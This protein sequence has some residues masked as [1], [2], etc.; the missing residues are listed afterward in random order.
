MNNG[1]FPAPVASGQFLISSASGSSIPQWSTYIP[2]G[3][4]QYDFDTNLGA[5][6]YIVNNTDIN[7][8][9]MV[10]G[11]TPVTIVLPISGTTFGQQST[12][13]AQTSQPITFSGVSGTNVVSVGA[14]PAMPQLRQIYS[15]ATATWLGGNGSTVNEWIVIGDVI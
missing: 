14:N 1:D 6:N 9:I 11:V 7:N 8:I 4:V 15:V 2:V 10:S 13:V 12:F 5:S 3:A